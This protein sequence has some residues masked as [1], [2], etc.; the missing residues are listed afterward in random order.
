MIRPLSDINSEFRAELADA[1]PPARDIPATGGNEDVADLVSALRETPKTEI[2]QSPPRYAIRIAIAIA[3]IILMIIAAVLL[4]KI[5]TPATGGDPANETQGG[6]D[7][8]AESDGP[9]AVTPGSEE[10]EYNSALENLE[11]EINSMRES[12]E[13][14]GAADTSDASADTSAGAES[15]SGAEASQ[16]ELAALYRDLIAPEHLAEILPL[17]TEGN[18]AARDRLTEQ[19]NARLLDGADKLAVS[20]PSDEEINSDTEFTNLTEPANALVDSINAGFTPGSRLPEVIDLRTKAFE[21]YPLRVLKKL[22]AIDYEDLGR[23]CAGA[24]RPAAD[25]FD[26][27]LNSVKYRTDYLRELSPESGVYYTEIRRIGRT[28]TNIAELGGADA[29]L[30]RH[31][32]LIAACLFEIAG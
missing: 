25:A 16:A 20:L 6:A 8:G 15:P 27:F 13:D 12:Q 23:Y 28:F 32:E 14:D 21:I 17:V 1:F 19:I 2:G 4:V 7:A 5:F 18:D 30:R 29:G 10:G 9:N 31:A 24:G 3:A 26:A 11:N 22:L